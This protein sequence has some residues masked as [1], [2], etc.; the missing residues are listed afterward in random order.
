MR[1]TRRKEIADLL[2]A[3]AM[4]VREL[5]RLFSADTSDI[6]TDLEHIARSIKPKERLEVQ[7]SMCRACGFVFKTREKLKKPSKCPRCKHEKITEP[8]FSIVQTA[9]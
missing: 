3:S 7:P 5:A 9:V 1:M 2:R 8:V 4:T 6:V